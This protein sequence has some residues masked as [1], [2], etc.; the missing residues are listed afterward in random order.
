MSDCLALLRAF[1]QW[2]IAGVKGLILSNMARRGRDVGRLYRG[3]YEKGMEKKEQE[4]RNALNLQ[5]NKKNQ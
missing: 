3:G 5:K 4:I 1:C 2:K